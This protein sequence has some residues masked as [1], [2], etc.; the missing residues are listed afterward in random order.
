MIPVALQLKGQPVLIVGGGQVAWRKAK[1]MLAE[2]AE[3]TI[4]APVIDEC[5]QALSVNLHVA[6]Y[7]RHLITSYFLVYA[8]TNQPEINHQ[9]IQDCQEAHILCGSATK[10]DQASF[11]SMA[12]LKNE[13]WLLGLSTY[14]QFPYTKPLLSKVQEALQP[15][16]E[17][18]KLLKQ[19]RPYLLEHHIANQTYFQLAYEAS[20]EMLSFLLLS[21]ITGYGYLFVYHQCETKP[22]LCLDVEPAMML[23]IEEYQHFISLWPPHIRYSVVPLVVADGYI[24][25]RIKQMTPAGANIYPPLFQTKQDITAIV[26][27]LQDTKHKLLCLMHPRSDHNLLFGVREVLGDAGC[28]YTFDEAFSIDKNVAY[29][30]VLFLMTKG[31]HYHDCLSI[32]DSFKK[33]GY[34]IVCVG[35]LLEQPAVWQRYQTRLLMDSKEI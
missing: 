34:N 14:Q 35:T 8:A 1:Q 25:Q 17:K 9:I 20:E 10:D 15:Y 27:A 24:Y 18:L 16:Q 30:V 32:I 28:A 5:F 31:K 3:I 23:S 29:R 26:T 2:G 22:D 6:A 19:I 21:L 7:E 12:V 11:Y 13:E 4:L 33:Q